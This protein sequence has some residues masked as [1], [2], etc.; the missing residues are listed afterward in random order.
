MA[1]GVQLCLKL[2]PSFLEIREGLPVSTSA[3]HLFPNSLVCPRKAPFL[4]NSTEVNPIHTRYVLSAGQT[5]LDL[6]WGLTF[7]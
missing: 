7:V 1:F 4:K 2:L 3:M 6:F 5:L